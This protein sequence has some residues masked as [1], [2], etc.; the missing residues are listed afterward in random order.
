AERPDEASDRPDHRALI[1]AAAAEAMVLLKNAGNVLPLNSDRLSSL[2]VIGPNARAARIHGG[3]SAQVN[4]H[5]A[6]TPFDGIVAQVGERL[7]IGYAF[8]CGNHRLLPRLDPSLLD[9]AAFAIDYF[10]SLDLS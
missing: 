9:G 3:G 1:R 6:V 5:Y 2:A 4:A 7:R 10:P 8:G